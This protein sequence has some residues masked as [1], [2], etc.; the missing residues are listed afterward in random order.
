VIVIKYLGERCRCL[1]NFAN[2]LQVLTL[3]PKSQV[4]AE[5]SF[6]RSYVN[7]YMVFWEGKCYNLCW[8]SFYA[9]LVLN[10]FLLAMGEDLTYSDVLEKPLLTTS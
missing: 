1:L 6:A 4:K 2:S 7:L 5:S 10:N 9:R 8:F 3:S